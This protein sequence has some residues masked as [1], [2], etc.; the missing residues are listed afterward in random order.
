MNSLV[1]LIVSTQIQNSIVL[2]HIEIVNG[3][4]VTTKIGENTRSDSNPI[5]LLITDYRINV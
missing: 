1:N 5:T 3:H 2:E 4:L